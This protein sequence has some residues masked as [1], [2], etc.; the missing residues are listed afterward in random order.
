[1]IL[2]RYL[3]AYLKDFL[4]SRKTAL[5]LTGARQTG[6]TFAIRQLGKKFTSFIVI[7]FIESP[8]FT[9]I[10]KEVNSAEEIY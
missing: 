4:N 9:R 2:F 8:A 10:F 3:T 6:K 5:L 7:N 1:M